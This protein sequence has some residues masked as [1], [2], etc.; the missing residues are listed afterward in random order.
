MPDSPNAPT[1]AYR[2]RGGRHAEL[3]D[4]RIAGDGTASLFLG[5]SYSIPLARVSKVGQFGGPAPPAEVA[6]IRHALTEHDILSR[7][8]SYGQ[9]TPDTPVRLLEIGDGERTV[10]LQLG[11]MTT[12]AVFDGLER[13]LQRLALALTNQPVRALEASLSLRRDGTLVTP[14]IEMR[15]IGPDPMTV[16]L[17]DSAQQTMTLRAWVAIEARV[18][19][20]SGTTMP[21]PLG[22]TQL[23]RNTVI[24]MAQQ[25]LLPRGIV[26]LPPDTRF[27]FDLP[28]IDVPQSG[29]PN[30]AT[31][32][33]EFW[34]PEGQAR[35]RLLLV[36]PEI[37]IPNAA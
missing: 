3:L 10:Q 36:T 2:A 21:M 23:E 16:L 26:D 17:V 12:D 22:T 8:G 25:D 15:R 37:P 9:I 20:P 32:F 1:I 31:G 27:T 19:L 14:A 6:A 11:G 24:T 28:P 33:V 5:S 13:A 18:T 4:L 7:G 29:M 35:H 34:W 30:V